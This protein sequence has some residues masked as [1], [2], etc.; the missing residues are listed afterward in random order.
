MCEIFDS[1]DDKKSQENSSDVKA[2]QAHIKLK[3]KELKI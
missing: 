2:E 3:N 1:N